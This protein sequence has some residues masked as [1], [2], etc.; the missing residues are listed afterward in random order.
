[1]PDEG[2]RESARYSQAHT[3][4]TL[5]TQASSN[6]TVNVSCRRAQAQAVW[7]LA[8]MGA[9]FRRFYT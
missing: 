5:A 1:M 3:S 8:L 2:G 7:E 6:D 4:A 9:S